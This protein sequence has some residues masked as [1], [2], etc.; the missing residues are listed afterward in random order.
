MF[1]GCVNVR[2]RGCKY[3][4]LRSR[5]FV[6]MCG[7]LIVHFCKCAVGRLQIYAVVLLCGC[8]VQ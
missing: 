5:A 8:R 4:N 3:T 2:S 6:R 7:R 1:C